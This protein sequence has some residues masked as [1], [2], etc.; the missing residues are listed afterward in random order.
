VQ[1]ARWFS[2]IAA[3]C[4]DKRGHSDGTL[5]LRRVA[6][7]TKANRRGGPPT[8]IASA[9]TQSMCSHETQNLSRQN[10]SEGP[11]CPVT[12]ADPRLPIAEAIARHASR[13][14]TPRSDVSPIKCGNVSRAK[15]TRHVALSD[16]CQTPC[17]SGDRFPRGGLRSRRLEVRALSRG[18]HRELK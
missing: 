14:R 13:Q 1:S 9:E 15:C 16:F 3:R 11:R 17:V 10:T 2:P 8:L 4:S 6:F 12:G 5:W 18:E 7:V